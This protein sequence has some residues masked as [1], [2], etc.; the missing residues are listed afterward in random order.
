MA[1]DAARLELARLLRGAHKRALEDVL[2]LLT[3]PARI[4]DVH[5]K[6]LLGAGD[7]GERA[8]ILSAGIEIGAVVG[9]AGVATVAKL[10]QHL[11]E[12][13]VEKLAL[14]AETLGRYKELTVL[15]D[16]SSSLSRV[17]DVDEV[18]TK[19]VGEAHRFLKASEA[20]LLI[21]DRRADR[22]E[23]LASAGGQATAIS[24]QGDGLEARAL[25]SAQAELVD[26]AQGGGSVIVAPLRSGDAA[27]GMLRVASTE[28]ERWNAGDLKLVT[29]LAAHAAS[30]ISHAML[31]RDQLRQQ[32][33]RG[34]IERFVSPT[35]LEAALEGADP[36]LEHEALAVLF[37]D[38]GQI[39]RSMDAS[40]SAGDVLA[41]M[42][43]AA[44]AAIDVLLEHGAT[45]NTAQGEMIIALFAATAE[46]S[47]AARAASA[48]GALG[49]R[50]DRA[51]GG[52]LDGAPGIGIAELSRGAGQEHA[53]FLEG[54]GTA[55]S[56][57]AE[58]AGRILVE[59]SIAA[60]LSPG[61]APF[62]L[63]P[64]E[65]VSA[66]RGSVDVYEVRL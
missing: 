60:R 47:A 25:R 61:T 14:A 28:S 52:M 27:F 48:A 59:A 16:M 65:K 8:P 44:S 41:A 66:P 17:L 54:V 10:V 63:V 64:A 3:E 11:H 26:H 22:L 23:P 1:R 51:S 9:G 18:A 4:E 13:E 30:A 15:Y 58:A 38:V 7:G 6:V 29:S 57:Q 42:L 21:L 34:Q 62:E 37:C 12:R 55:A 32:A 24:V 40:A 35:L 49:K 20:A 31:H 46:I 33:M 43:H 19:I 39:A 53:S 45:L 56:L 36:S 2:T 5:G 50:L